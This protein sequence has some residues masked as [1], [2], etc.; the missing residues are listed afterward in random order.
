M[1][2]DS[3]DAKDV[4]K[5]M[6]GVLAQMTFTD[7]PYNVDYKYAKYEAIHKGRKKKFMDA[8]RIFNDK[9][10]SEEFY[11]FLLDS[12]RNVYNFT[13]D[14]ATIYVCYATKTELEF[15][16]AFRDAGWLFSQTIIWLKERIILALGQ[17][18]HRVYEPILFGWKEGNK[19]MT[20]KKLTTEKEV[21]DPD[22]LSFEE[23][24][25]VWYLHRDKS[26]DYV[27][28]TQKP[29]SLPERAIKKHTNLGDI[30]LEPF[31]GSGSTLIACE[32]LGRVCYCNEIDPRYC[33]VIRLRY[34]NYIKSKSNEVGNPVDGFVGQETENQ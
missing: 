34:N 25:D 22:K 18:Y 30:V 23:R 20:N 2:G 3:T 16:T 29:V 12:L 24:L 21:W 15:R 4:E 7:P 14:S 8:G 17:D 5:L 13:V 11:H 27:H 10:T 32:Q 31:A 33:D 9:K 6:G 1:C 28:P 26:A 19:R